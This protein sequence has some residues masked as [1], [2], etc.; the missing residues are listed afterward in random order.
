MAQKMVKIHMKNR[1]VNIIPEANLSN[2]KRIFFAQI[3]FIEEDEGEPIIAKP[4][5][6]EIKSP[7]I[8]EIKTPVVETPKVETTKA[9]MSMSKGELQKLAKDLDGYDA[10]LNKSQLVELIN[11]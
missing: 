7:V 4:I 2:F 9:D 8:E 6:E 3:D 5:I 1:K 10:K 11:K